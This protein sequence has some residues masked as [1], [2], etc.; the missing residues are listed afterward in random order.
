MTREYADITWDAIVIGTGI[1]GGTVGRRLAE[2]GQ[3]VLFVEKGPAG[4]RREETAMDHDIFDPTARL[5]RGLWPG[6]MHGKI[7]GQDTRFFPPI[8]AGIGGSSVFYAATLERP[9]PHD[10]NH[11][12]TRPHPTHGWPVSWD[13]FAPWL[14]QAEQIYH[15]SGGHDPLAK[16][17]SKTMLPARPFS[18][19]DADI[20]QHFLNNNLHPYALHSALRHVE[21]CKECLGFKC[22]K[23]CKMDGRSAGVEPAMITGNATIL[24]RCEVTKIH[25]DLGQVTHITVRKDGE[26]IDLVARQYVLAGGAFGSPRLLLASANETWPGGVANHSGLVGRNLMFH[27][28]EM[29]AIWP[30][31]THHN[32][33]S[34]ETPGPSKS[35]GFR[36]L[37][38]I[39]GHRLGMVQAMGI[40]ASYGEIAHYMRQWVANSSFRNVPLA[41]EL[42]R[43][44]A[45]AAAKI[46]GNAKIFVGLLEDLPYEKNRVLAP[47]NSDDIGFEYRISD[48]LKTRRRIFRREIRRAMR[49][50]RRMFLT[51]K[52]ELNFGHPS[53]TLCFGNDPTKSVLRPDGR[54]HDIANL[55]AADASFMPTSMGVNPSLT[56]AAQ[57]L[58][59]ADAITQIGGQNGAK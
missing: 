47:T 49:G 25:A 7:D 32:A 58:R 50:Q 59:V 39:N 38:H 2:A 24:D 5:V 20:A 37:Y 48:E 6:Q 3:K 44:P 36:D 43:I 34:D 35:V 19:Q 17:H 51:H 21:G 16:H 29:F 45:M 27:L 10:L 40:D 30:K 12:E 18:P 53:G 13:D 1:G 56:I 8:G 22:P 11:T 9:E 54:C 46:L 26:N 4:Y 15:V 33:I 57:A 31:R 28:N 14:D 23:L 52:P 42:T 41:Q 55:W